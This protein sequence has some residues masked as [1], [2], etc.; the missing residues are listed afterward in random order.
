M[1]IQTVFGDVIKT[2][3]AT[4]LYPAVDLAIK[5]LQAYTTAMPDVKKRILCF[6]DG[7]GR[8]FLLSSLNI[9]FLFSSYS[10]VCI[11]FC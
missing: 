9:S 2:E 7:G 1:F 10:L 3:G 5:R 8:N 4:N 11:L 6:T